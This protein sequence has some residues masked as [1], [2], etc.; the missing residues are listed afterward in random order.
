MSVDTKRL[1]ELLADYLDEH[2]AYDAATDVMEQL[3]ALLDEL[4]LL[5]K[6]EAAT[7]KY[8]DDIHRDGCDICDPTLAQGV[9]VTDIT[10]AIAES[11][12]AKE[13]DRG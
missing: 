5:R 13:G 12:K 3:S 7:L 9:D 1:R 6:F 10:A 2:N 8:W 4:D 11:R